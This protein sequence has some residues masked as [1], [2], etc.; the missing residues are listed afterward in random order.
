MLPVQIN[1]VHLR[2]RFRW[3]PDENRVP[4]TLSD[5]PTPWAE[6]SQ[7]PIEKCF[8]FFFRSFSDQNRRF[9]DVMKLLRC[10]QFFGE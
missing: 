4:C 3:A 5:T 9:T 1:Q 2:L 10:A 6:H 8:L 7:Q